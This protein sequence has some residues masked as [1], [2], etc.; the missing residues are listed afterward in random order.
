[1]GEKTVNPIIEG[2]IGQVVGAVVKEI[3]NT[4]NKNK[5]G[6]RL[7]DFIEQVVKDS[8]TKID[9]ATV[10]PVVK[11]LRSALDISETAGS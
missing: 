11:A 7:F 6:G 3:V 2:M 1:M 9:D 8:E 10:L 5:Y 4:E